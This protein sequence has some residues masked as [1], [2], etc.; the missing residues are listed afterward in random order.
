MTST[1]T[2]DRRFCGPP[3]SAN[4][5]YTC[6]VLA[7][8]IQGAAEVTLRSPPPLDRP[9]TID[10]DTEG[11]ALHDGDVVVATARGT[12]VDLDVPAVPSLADAVRAAAHSPL[13]DDHPYPTCFVCG[14]NRAPGD[15]LRLLCGPVDGRRV[16]AARWCPEWSLA[17]EDGVVLPEFVWSAL[18]CPSGVVTALLGEVGLIVLGRLA[19]DLRSDVRAGEPHVVMAWPVSR[20]GRKLHTAAAVCTQEGTLCAVARATWIEIPGHR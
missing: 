8:A 18:D 1:T 15:G 7:G 6:G 10:V 19:A 20:D 4:G 13:H 16:Y 12:L 9:L 17:G 2:I 5:G 14:P 3:R 11:A